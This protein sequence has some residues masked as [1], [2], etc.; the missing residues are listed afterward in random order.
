[1]IL[2]SAQKAQ[3]SVAVTQD[4]IDVTEETL[5]KKNGALAKLRGL[6]GE[7]KQGAEKEWLQSAVERNTNYFQSVTKKRGKAVGLNSECKMR[8]GPFYRFIHAPSGL[9]CYCC[10][11]RCVTVI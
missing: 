4:A 8:F 3:H 9:L 11:C 7:V 6:T 2:A 10:C 1:M 5:A